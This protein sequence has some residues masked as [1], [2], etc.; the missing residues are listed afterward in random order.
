[1]AACIMVVRYLT[2]VAAYPQ[3]KKCCAATE[4]D[5]ELQ[6]IHLTV[7]RGRSYRLIQPP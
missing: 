3:M 4:Y 5:C 7:V 1:M 6:I 2:V